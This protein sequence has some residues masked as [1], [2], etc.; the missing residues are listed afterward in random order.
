MCEQ[1]SF[2]QKKKK[3]AS[4]QSLFTHPASQ[5]Q[6][7]SSKLGRRQ[8]DQKKAPNFAKMV[9]NSPKMAVNIDI[10]AYFLSR[11]ISDKI[12]KRKRP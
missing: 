10:S 9:Q 12:K 7:R 3:E 4:K 11:L 6:K 1:S 5:P 2:A 8:C